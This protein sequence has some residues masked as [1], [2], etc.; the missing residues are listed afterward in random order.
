[1]PTQDH[2]NG[3]MLKYQH[4]PL[5]IPQKI[6][7][8]CKSLYWHSETQV[9]GPKVHTCARAH[10][11]TQI[12]ANMSNK[13]VTVHETV[14]KYFEDFMVF[15]SHW[16]AHS[17]TCHLSIKKMLHLEETMKQK[18]GAERGAVPWTLL[19][20]RC[21]VTGAK[22][23]RQCSAWRGWGWH[24][25]LC[26]WDGREQCMKNGVK[27]CEWGNK[28]LHGQEDFRAYPKVAVPKKEPL[29]GLQ[30]FCLW[31]EEERTRPLFLVS[32]LHVK[33]RR[34]S[35]VARDKDR[36]LTAETGSDMHV[37]FK[38][39]LKLFYWL[40]FLMP[41]AKIPKSSSDS[42]NMLFTFLLYHE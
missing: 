39:F 15:F 40:T 14:V 9:Q 13:T 17:S 19:F 33:C 31:S 25:R 6:Y 5:W 32:S 27:C 18:I 35:L 1:M 26:R 2:Y 42:K 8:F 30:C 24:P 41:F 29:C 37:Y 20:G 36:Q 4:P 34:D 28:D 10:T 7:S 23:K 38:F 16:Y 12:H 3:Q 21:Y 22:L 11:H